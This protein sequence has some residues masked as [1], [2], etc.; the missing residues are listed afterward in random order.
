MLVHAPRISPA[1]ES[2]IVVAS[3]WRGLLS[4]CAGASA[5]GWVERLATFPFFASLFF[6][7]GFYLFSLVSVFFLFHL[8]SFSSGLLGI[9][10]VVA[11]N[12]E[13]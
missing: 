10:A 8:P 4:K 2:S 6:L 3:S 12:L 13:R 11:A 1:S 5:P 7:L 9:S